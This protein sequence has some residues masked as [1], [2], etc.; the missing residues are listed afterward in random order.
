MIVS[1]Q[2]ITAVLLYRGTAC[3]W[4]ICPTFHFNFTA[5]VHCSY[6]IGLMFDIDILMSGNSLKFG[7]KGKQQ[8]KE[9]HNII[10]KIR[11]LIGL[12]VYTTM[13]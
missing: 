1:L 8:K 3:L 10:N 13:F 6:G 9:N 11:C 7:L 12:I 2:S 4:S 5:I